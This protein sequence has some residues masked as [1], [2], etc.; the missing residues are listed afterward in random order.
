MI[1]ERSL[2]VA[3]P[4]CS[5][6]QAP[7]GMAD[8]L[9]EW[10]HARI[11]RV[12]ETQSSKS[13]IKLVKLS[14]IS[15]GEKYVLNCLITWISD[16]NRNAEA[17]ALPRNNAYY[18]R[19]VHH[20]CERFGLAHET[21][22]TE[23]DKKVFYCDSHNLYLHNVPKKW[24]VWDCAGYYCTNSRMMNYYSIYSDTKS[25]KDASLHCGCSLEKRYIP[26][27]VTLVTIPSTV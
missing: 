10:F 14:K 25:C 22:A 9:V 7:S 17:F 21:I 20:W 3:T 4:I 2:D 19:I 12:T 26:D 11:N 5:Q 8:E 24:I 15:N 23:K 27:R 16:R 1:A 18:R 13:M 6:A